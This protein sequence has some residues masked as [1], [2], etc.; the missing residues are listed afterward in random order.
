LL[1]GRTTKLTPESQATITSSIADGLPFRVAC[2]RAGIS[3]V[4]FES[5]RRRGERDRQGIFFDF[6]I[7][8]KK[9]EA[10][11]IARNV[12]IIQQAATDGTWTASAWWLER[13]YPEEWGRREHVTVVNR[14]ALIDAEVERLRAE[15]PDVPSER[16]VAFAD[17][18]K[19]RRAG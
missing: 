3:M 13:R 12:G 7:A 6:R 15:F 1:A 14:D 4:T 10:D 2:Q 17:Q 18:V 19:R 11:A 16:I 9:A 5:W 8:V